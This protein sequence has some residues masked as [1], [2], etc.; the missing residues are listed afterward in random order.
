MKLF[1]TLNKFQLDILS[2]NEAYKTQQTNK[3]T[4]NFIMLKTQ[5]FINFM[6]SLSL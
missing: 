6:F 2:V 1:F 5:N 4:Q 3:F